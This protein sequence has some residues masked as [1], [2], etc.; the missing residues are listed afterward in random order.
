MFQMMRFGALICPSP[1]VGYAKRIVVASGF[2]TTR[3]FDS[4]TVGGPNAGSGAEMRV[5]IG[6]LYG[7]DSTTRLVA[8]SRSH[9]AL[10][11]TPDRNACFCHDGLRVSAVPD[12]LPAL[13]VRPCSFPR[14]VPIPLSFGTA[15]G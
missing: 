12:R 1:R 15:P 9:G 2:E 11:A 14:I 10:Y 4:V 6:P 13:F 3:P 7:P 8:K 5:T